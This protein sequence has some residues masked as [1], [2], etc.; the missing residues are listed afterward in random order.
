MVVSCCCRNRGARLRVLILPSGGRGLG[1]VR[2][3]LVLALQ[4]RASVFFRRSLSNT[5]CPGTYRDSACLPSASCVG[6]IRGRGNR[7]RKLGGWLAEVVVALVSGLI[8][9]FVMGRLYACRVA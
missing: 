5:C 6:C 3:T 9:A 4:D 7:G 1:S 8:A 2:R